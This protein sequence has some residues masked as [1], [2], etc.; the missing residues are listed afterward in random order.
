MSRIILTPE[1]P[2]ESQGPQI[3]GQVKIA[4]DTQGSIYTQA[5]DSP[6]IP[7][8]ASNTVDKEGYPYQ[9]LQYI[10][11]RR[12]AFNY[13]RENTGEFKSDKNILFPRSNYSTVNTRPENLDSFVAISD[14]ADFRGNYTIESI[15]RKNFIPPLNTYKYSDD[16]KNTIESMGISLTTDFADIVTGRKTHGGD[17]TAL[18]DDST[19]ID[20][21]RPKKPMIWEILEPTG[22]PWI[23]NQDIPARALPDRPFYWKMR[24]YVE[25]FLPVEHS[26]SNFLIGIIV[27]YYH[28]LKIPKGTPLQAFAD[29]S[30]AKIPSPHDIFLEMPTQNVRE[31]H[32]GYSLT[33]HITGLREELETFTSETIVSQFGIPYELVQLFQVYMQYSRMELEYRIYDNNVRVA[34]ESYFPMEHD[35][36]KLMWAIDDQGNKIYP[37]AALDTRNYSGG[38][39]GIF[40]SLQSALKYSFEGEELEFVNS[41]PTEPFLAID[42]HDIY[43]HGGQFAYWQHPNFLRAK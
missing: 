25:I 43:T 32:S 33:T 28:C 7:A 6:A 36:A 22:I 38:I 1:N 8:I 35:Y 29:E 11:E 23:L 27:K 5:K 24:G 4:V 34:P 19:T 39:Q 42:L 18:S 16:V 10:T 20:Y 12:N 15:K 41:R 3:D 9:F 40:K 26:L 17:K 2:E 21:H 30:V 31:I 14:T 13:P 37:D